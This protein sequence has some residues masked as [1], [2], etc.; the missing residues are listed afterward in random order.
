M[1]IQRSEHIREQYTTARKGRS[2]KVEGRQISTEELNLRIFTRITVTCVI[3]DECIHE[4]TFNIIQRMRQHTHII[5]PCLVFIVIFVMHHVSVMVQYEHDK[6]TKFRCPYIMCSKSTQIKNDEIKVAA[7]SNTSVK[8]HPTEHFLTLF[9]TFDPNM[10]KFV[11]YNNTLHNWKLLKPDVKLVFF[12]D[13]NKLRTHVK[14]IGWDVTLR[15]PHKSCNGTPVLKEMFLKI[16]SIFKSKFYAYANADILFDRGLLNTLHYLSKFHRLY[17]HPLLVSGKRMDFHIDR[18]NTERISGY[19]DIENLIIQS[20]MSYGFAEDYFIVNSQFPWK[21]VSDVVIGRSMVD[22]Y[23]VYMARKNR[24]INV[25]DS[26]ATIGALHQKTDQRIKIKMG[27]C[28]RK[29]IGSKFSRHMISRGNIECAPW[30]T[31]NI[32]NEIAFIKRGMFTT[33]C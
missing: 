32:N 27:N 9:T 31:R 33:V 25:I 24:N 16:K 19:T 2:V 1:I 14:S 12:S 29:I 10:E 3:F 11:V 26:S 30:E 15:I 13:D 5:L 21:I 7:K 28:N 18:L 22:N 8:L 20:S 23:I 6:A 4:F 17:Y